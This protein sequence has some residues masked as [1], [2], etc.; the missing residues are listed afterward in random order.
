MLFPSFSFGKKSGEG[1]EFQNLIKI[2]NYKI[3]KE[4]H[5]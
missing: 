2:K 4:S 1:E 5:C 3:I